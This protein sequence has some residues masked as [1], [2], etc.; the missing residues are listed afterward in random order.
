MERRTVGA[1]KDVDIHSVGSVVTDEIGE[2]AAPKR[3]LLSNR[4]LDG[5]PAVSIELDGVEWGTGDLDR[6]GEQDSGG[7]R[8]RPDRNAQTPKCLGCSNSCCESHERQTADHTDK[9][10]WP[11]HHRNPPCLMRTRPLGGKHHWRAAPG[12][13][14]ES[15]ETSGREALPS[16]IRDA[17][18]RPSISASLL[19]CAGSVLLGW[20]PYVKSDSRVEAA[21]TRFSAGG[22]SAERLKLLLELLRPA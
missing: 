18:M 2:A 20:V 5:N 11:S 12:S 1:S 17:A 21:R 14:A 15:A 3:D 13:H 16:V 22:P 8:S 4:L 7:Q 10:Q 19:I 6:D 9:P